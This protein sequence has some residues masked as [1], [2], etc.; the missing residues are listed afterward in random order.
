[1]TLAQAVISLV[2]LGALAFGVLAL[3]YLRDTSDGLNLSGHRAE[4]LPE[5][6][7]DR[8]V[9]FA[10]LALMAA[11]Y[12]DYMVI[13]ALFAVFAVMGL[14]DAWIYA[15]GGYGYARHLAAG[16]AGF[17]VTGLALIALGISGDMTS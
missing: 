15:R 10:A 16:L 3:V 13:A 2:G 9:G 4:K 6:M 1:M 5:V 17:L 12:G 7:A 11:L 14:A 8:Y